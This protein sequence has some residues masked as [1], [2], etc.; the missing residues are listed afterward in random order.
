LDLLGRKTMTILMEYSRLDHQVL[1]CLFEEPGT[2]TGNSAFQLSI[3]SS[4]PRTVRVEIDGELRR[5]YQCAIPS[6]LEGI[7]WLECDGA[8]FGLDKSR[9]Y[10]VYLQAHA[11]TKLRERLAVSFNTEVI[12][13]LGLSW[14]LD[15]L[16][17]L[18]PQNDSY[19]IAFHVRGIRLG[20]LVAKV[21]EDKV[22]IR[23]FLFLTMEGTPEGRLLWRNLQLTRRDIEYTR[24]DRLETFLAPDI[25]ADKELVGL[26]EEC[27][28]G[29]LL[30]LARK[31]FGHAV[32]NASAEDLRRFLRLDEEA[33][34]KLLARL[35]PQRPQVA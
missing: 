3:Q 14:S 4:E 17:V 29:S 35:S 12:L 25:L 15:E 10:P 5:A 34:K 8:A 2:F 1:G 9:R 19:L 27:G 31:G 13:H 23:T 18:G 16:T 32:V 21:V 28:C 24:L 7:E 26:L 11:L 22:I 33:G 6:G 20:Y 30:E